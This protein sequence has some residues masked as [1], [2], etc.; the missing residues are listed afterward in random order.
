MAHRLQRAKAACRCDCFQ[1]SSGRPFQMLLS[2]SKPFGHDPF[3]G[4]RSGRILKSTLKRAGAHTS[5]FRE[6]FDRMEL[7]QIGAQPVDQRAKAE[8]LALIEHRPLHKLNLTTFTVWRNDQSPCDRIS[9][10]G[11]ILFPDHVQAQI[12]ARRA[13]GRGKHVTFVDIQHIR[14]KADRRISG[15]DRLCIS[16]MGRRPS[17]IEQA[18]AARTAMPEQSDMILAPRA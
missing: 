11:S 17:P 18:C 4:R 12:D 2:K 15:I 6:R 16:P 13:T 8:I 10:F 3:A 5:S 14:F 1:G 9:R 7:V